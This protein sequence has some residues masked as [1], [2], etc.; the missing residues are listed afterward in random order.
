MPWS[1]PGSP[2]TFPT[3]CNCCR[4]QPKPTPA[5]GQ[6]RYFHNCLQERKGVIWKWFIVAVWQKN[7]KQPSA[8]SWWSAIPESDS[9]LSCVTTLE[10][11]GKW[12]LQVWK[13]DGTGIAQRR[14]SQGPH[15]EVR[16][17]ISTGKISA[18]YPQGK[19]GV[20]HSVSRMEKSC[21]SSLPNFHPW[22][23]KVCGLRQSSLWGHFLF[24]WI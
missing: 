23:G 6:V 12:Y 2:L 24:T 11:G 5:P 17:P 8:F 13:R 18:K 10:R 16:N 7:Y 9:S 19:K 22:L 3:S 15:G 14:C 4:Q 20:G 1:N 21:E